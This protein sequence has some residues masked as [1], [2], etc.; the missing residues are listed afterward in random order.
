VLLLLTAHPAGRRLT[1]LNEIMAQHFLRQLLCSAVIAAAAVA[2]WPSP[3]WA[4]G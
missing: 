4:Q 2:F 1:S 3:A